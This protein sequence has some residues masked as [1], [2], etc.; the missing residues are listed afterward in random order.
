M[1]R[2]WRSK[3]LALGFLSGLDEEEPSTLLGQK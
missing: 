2:Q 1:E 3:G